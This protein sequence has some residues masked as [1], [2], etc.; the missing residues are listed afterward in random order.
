MAMDISLQNHSAESYN[1]PNTIA[2]GGVEAGT[3]MKLLLSHISLSAGCEPLYFI[4][5]QTDDL[6]SKIFAFFPNKLSATEAKI[7]T[8]DWFDGL[9][10]LNG[11]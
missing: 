4:V 7:E 2:M 10:G 3:S 5:G 8:F 9:Y 6:A 1:K 11:F